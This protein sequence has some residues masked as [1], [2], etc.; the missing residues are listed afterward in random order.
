MYYLN[1]NALQKDGP[2]TT[3][4]LTLNSGISNIKLGKTFKFHAF[5]AL[6]YLYADGNI[7]YFFTATGILTKN[8]WPLRLESTINQPFRTDIP[9]S[10]KFL[11][12]V[13]L[14]YFFEKRMVHSI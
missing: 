12:N 13:T 7:G 2:Q 1:G 11:W 6:Y 14:S 9:G 4:F 5:P 3:H 10:E 8:N